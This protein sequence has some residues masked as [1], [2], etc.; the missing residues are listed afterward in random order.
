M[1]D[2]L[3]LHSV[4][5]LKQYIDL[6]YFLYLIE[7][8]HILRK[9]A[10]L[11]TTSYRPTPFQ[12]RSTIILLSRLHEVLALHHNY[13]RRK[14]PIECILPS[15]PYIS[16]PPRPHRRTYSMI[17]RILPTAQPRLHIPIQGTGVA[18]SSTS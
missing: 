12:C 1:V 10:R 16:M 2:G 3:A 17:P 9:C 15:S 7:H 4:G 14:I 18:A 13:K 11:S 6:S 8:S 5:S